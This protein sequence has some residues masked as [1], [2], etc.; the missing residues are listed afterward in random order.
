MVPPAQMSA[1]TRITHRFDGLLIALLA[2]GAASLLHFSHNAIYIDEYP[3]LPA[4][5]TSF[6]V[7]ATWCAEAA[8]GLGGF[9]LYAKGIRRT[10]LLMIVL[11]AALAYDG[12]AHYGR[13]PM[14]AHTFA[15]NFTIWF[16]VIA[17]TALLAI[18]GT[19]LVRLIT[20]SPRLRQS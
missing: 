12:L 10:G 17:G 15:M 19:Q 7:W 9:L 8:I 2:Y 5:L 4:W 13:A 18:A 14:F 11:Y 20:G 1:E 16:E 3:N 6:K